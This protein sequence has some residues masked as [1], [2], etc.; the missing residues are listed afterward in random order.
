[1]ADYQ[2]PRYRKI[3]KLV[4]M[5]GLVTNNSGSSKAGGSA[6]FTANLAEAY[7]PTG[8]RITNLSLTIAVEVRPDGAVVNN[9]SVANGSFCGLTMVWAV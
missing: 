5:E 8:G 3:G 1:M 4:C 7:R 6:I 2:A 9:A